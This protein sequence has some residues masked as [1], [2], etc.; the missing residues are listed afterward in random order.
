[1]TKLNKKKKKK[2][3][4]SGINQLDDWLMRVVFGDI[5]QG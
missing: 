4:Q 2:N 5:L 1:M 3:K